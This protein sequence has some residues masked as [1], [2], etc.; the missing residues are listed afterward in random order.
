MTCRQPGCGHEFCWVC[1]ADYRAILR[2]GNDRHAPACRYH[3]DNLGVTD[4]EDVEDEEED[5][6]EEVEE[7]EEGNEEQEEEGE[8][9]GR[10]GT[11]LRGRGLLL[12]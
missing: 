12:A 4:D 3:T 1:L 8:E 6:E 11:G 2:R 10:G 5:E 9:E 7:E